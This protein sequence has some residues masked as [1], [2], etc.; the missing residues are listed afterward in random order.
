MAARLRAA[1]P[2]HQRRQKIGHRAFEQLEREWVRR[3][4]D[5]A[6][7]TADFVALASKVARRDLSGFLNAWIY[8]ET[9]PAMPGHRDR[10]VDPVEE[11]ATARALARAPARR[12]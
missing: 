7:R 12:R 5:G 4:R 6:V 9:T 2:G 11:E 10:T 1:R 8:G 3:H